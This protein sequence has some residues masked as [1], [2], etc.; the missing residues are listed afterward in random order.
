M[1]LAY[2]IPVLAEESIKG[3]NLMPASDAVDAT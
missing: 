1:T 2:H 3:M